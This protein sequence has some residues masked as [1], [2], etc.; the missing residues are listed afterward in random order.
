VELFW[1]FLKEQIRYLPY[2]EDFGHL[3]EKIIEITVS[4]SMNF[5]FRWFFEAITKWQ[6]KPKKK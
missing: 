6:H 5:V 2:I 4:I 3:E 1:R